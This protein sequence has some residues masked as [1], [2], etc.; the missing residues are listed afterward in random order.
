MSEA[1]YVAGPHCGGP[2]CF[3]I[4]GVSMNNDR[5]DISLQIAALLDRHHVMS[6]ATVC[7]DGPQ[8]AN[9]FYA[10]DG[11]A[12]LWVSELSSRHS[13]AV[14]S[15]AR[16]AATIAMDYSDFPEIQGLQISGRAFRV[17][18]ELPR[19][20]ARRCLEARYPFLHT[21]ANAPEELRTAYE[22]AQ[23]YRLEPARITII[24]NT[25]GLGFKQTLDFPSSG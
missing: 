21:A 13:V 10:R 6:L 11:L 4:S 5:Q 22:H 25:R 12:L 1:I 9:L 23:F 7:L 24:D 8:A 20:N 14:E 16:V 19:Q 15:D 18:E 2:V 17:I 3:C